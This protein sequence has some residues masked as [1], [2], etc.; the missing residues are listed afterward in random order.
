MQKSKCNISTKPILVLLHFMMS[1]TL[2][3]HFKA[4]ERFL[5]SIL[6]GVVSIYPHFQEL[7]KV[8]SIQKTMSYSKS[9]MKTFWRISAQ[10]SLNF[11]SINL[12]LSALFFSAVHLRISQTHKNCWYTWATPKTKQ[13]ARL[14]SWAACNLVATRHTTASSNTGWSTDTVEQATWPQAELRMYKTKSSSTLVHHNPNMMI[15]H[16]YHASIFCSRGRSQSTLTY[17]LHNWPFFQEL[18]YSSVM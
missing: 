7:L 9:P 8:S 2:Y 1:A 4:S 6:K 15:S 14:S 16:P 12:L 11:V 17:R 5:G 18:V 10:K 13:L 3:T